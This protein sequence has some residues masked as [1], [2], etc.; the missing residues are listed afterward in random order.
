VVSGDKF[1]VQY[2]GQYS[3]WPEKYGAEAYFLHRVDLH[4]GL[5]G[6]AL[7]AGP[8]LRPAKINLSSEVVDLDCETGIITLANGSTHK[9]DVIVVADGVHVSR[10]DQAMIGYGTDINTSVK[11]RFVRKVIGH[12]IPAKTTGHSAFRFMI[13][14][15]TLLESEEIKPLFENAVSGIDVITLGE[16]RL[17]WY[18]CRSLVCPVCRPWLHCSNA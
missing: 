15:E 16:R 14:T 2:Y 6:L 11:S 4:N 12:D 9:E 13:P 8:G 5:K 1:E 18:P 7:D 3:H 17:V 10:A